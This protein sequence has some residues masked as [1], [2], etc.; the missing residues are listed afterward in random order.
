MQNPKSLFQSKVAELDGQR[1][2][3]P[4]NLEGREK[5]RNGGRREGKR[6]EREEKK[7]K[8]PSSS[9]GDVDPSGHNSISFPSMSSRH[10][11][12]FNHGHVK[13]GTYT[14]SGII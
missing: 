8:I 4:P 11:S 9:W 10:A 13:L 2:L 12:T 3:W 14:I 6:E 5:G 1:G 7:K